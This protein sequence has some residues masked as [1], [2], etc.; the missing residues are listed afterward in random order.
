MFFVK[1]YLVH[2]CDINKPLMT[3]KLNK[4]PLNIQ[5]LF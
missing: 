1:Q 4:L 3:D 5:Q 2:Q